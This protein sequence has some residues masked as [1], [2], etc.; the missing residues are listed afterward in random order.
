MKTK[1]ILYFML[2]GLIFVVSC[3]QNDQGKEKDLVS[4]LDSVSYCLGVSVGNNIQSSFDTVDPGIIAQAINDV[5]MENALKMDPDQANQYLSQY[6]SKKQ[7]KIADE[8]K[9]E[10]DDFLEENKDKE[11]VKTTESGLQYKIIKEGNGPSPEADSRVKVH[12]HGTF[13]DGDVF[14]SSVERGEPAEFVVGQVIKGWQEA[15]QMMKVGGKWQLYIPPQL[16]YGDNTR[17]RMEPNKMLIFEVELIDI[18]EK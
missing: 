12:Y 1:N 18:L 17:G 9:A 6:F 13:V 11:G 16:A 7:D 3:S 8:N 15:L 14:D 10:S 5:Y 2:A 4:D